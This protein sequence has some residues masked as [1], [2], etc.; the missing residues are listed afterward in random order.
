MLLL[1]RRIVRWWK[2]LRPDESVRGRTTAF[3]DEENVWSDAMDDIVADLLYKGPGGTD[4][5]DDD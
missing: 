2:R 4:D 5:D 3:E 1:L